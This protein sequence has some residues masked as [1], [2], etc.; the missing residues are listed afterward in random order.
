MHVRSTIGLGTAALVLALAACSSETTPA[1]PSLSAT[2]NGYPSGSH[3]NLNI[4]GVSKDKTAD[5]TGDNGRRIFMPLE[6]KSSIYLSEGDFGVLDANGT[7]GRAEFQLPAADADND[8]V[9]TYSVFARALGKPGGS[10]STT[11]CATDKATGE[12]WC[13]VESMTLERKTGKSTATNVSREL[14][15]IYYDAD[16]DGTA[17]RYPLFDTSLQDFFWAYDNN[18]LK[19]AQLRFYPCSTNVETGS[20]ACFQ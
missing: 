4:I 2:S 17:E 9:T 20:T 19:L 6:G 7:D 10:S 13:S 15:Y 5:M 1:G 16:G 8:G 18:G 12:L 3:Y 14:L 11:T